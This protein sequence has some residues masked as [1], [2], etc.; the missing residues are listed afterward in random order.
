M[1]PWLSKL[2]HSSTS[3]AMHLSKV[4]RERGCVEK[5]INI[6]AG[7]LDM[8]GSRPTWAGSGSPGREKALSQHWGTPAKQ[9]R[10]PGDICKDS[11]EDNF[12]QD[13]L[14]HH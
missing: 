5:P 6:P 4:I 10:A 2:D 9:L 13:V 7:T 14:V 1:V 11:P 3:E 8:T 12:G